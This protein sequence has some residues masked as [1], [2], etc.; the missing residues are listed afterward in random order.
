MSAH[1]YIP[2]ISVTAMPRPRT[3]HDFG[4]FPKELY[5]ID[6]PAPGDQA[7]A[8]KVKDLLAP[9]DV[10]FDNE[11]G[12]DH[13]TWSVLCHIFPEADIPVVQLSIDSTK[14]PSFHH[15]LGNLLSS[16]RDGGVLLLGSGNIVHNLREYQWDTRADFKAFDWAKRFDEKVR[17]LLYAENDAQLIDYPS[18]GRDATLS[19]PTPEHYLP[20]LYILGSRRKGESVYFPA[21]G[22]EGG[23]LSMTAVRIG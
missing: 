18:M 1:W 14:P 5:T 21:E 11:W 16:L 10:V 17:E 13:G 7:L 2:S 8:A 20:L 3:I 4:G 6:Y 12:L 19:V 9:T 22:F 23:S 15:A